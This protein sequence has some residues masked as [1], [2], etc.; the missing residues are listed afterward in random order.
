MG[1]VFKIGEPG[2]WPAKPSDFPKCGNWLPSVDDDDGDDDDYAGVELAPDARDSND[3][4][5]DLA[6]LLHRDDVNALESKST[7]AY[8]DISISHNHLGNLSHSEPT[9]TVH[10]AGASASV[11]SFS[12]G[13]H[14]VIA[15]S[16][17]FLL[18]SSIESLQFA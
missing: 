1:L 4:S 9:A 8:L 14:L 12:F 17:Y 18:Q 3:I 15:L 2:D 16:L 6:P 13:S 11:H 10:L 7:N 5:N